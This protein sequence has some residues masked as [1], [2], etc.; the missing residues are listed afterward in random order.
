MPSTWDETRFIDGYPGK[1]AVL[2]RR[3]GSRW[4]VAALNGTDKPLQLN[5]SL[6]MLA[7]K[8]VDFYYETADKKS[9]WPK[10]AVRK[11]KVGKDGKF[12]I[13]IQPMGGNIIN[14]L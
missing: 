2:A 7:G 10:S 11:T 6:P 3:H 12:K 1:Y 13:M 9:L 8:D 5:L 4:Y 14:S